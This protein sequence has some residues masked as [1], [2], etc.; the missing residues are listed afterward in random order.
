MR[1]PDSLLSYLLLKQ[2]GNHDGEKPSFLVLSSSQTWASGLQLLNVSNCS[3]STSEEK[4]CY[5]LPS[6]P[7]RGLTPPTLPQNCCEHQNRVTCCVVD[8]FPIIESCSGG[9]P[10]DLRP[11]MVIARIVLTAVST[12]VAFLPYQTLS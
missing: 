6:S 1:K 2:T 9:P 11:R 4:H 7:S 10:A 3:S 5:L 8:G 12:T